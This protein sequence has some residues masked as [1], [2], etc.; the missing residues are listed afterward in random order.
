[1][2]ASVVTTLPVFLLFLPLQS[3]LSAGLTAGAVK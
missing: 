2:A 1:M 3:K